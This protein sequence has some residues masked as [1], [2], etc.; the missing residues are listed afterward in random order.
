MT[1]ANKVSYRQSRPYLTSKIAGKEIARPE[2]TSLKVEK[3]IAK[4]DAANETNAPN[5]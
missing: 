3:I 2:A 4:A 1:V 5:M